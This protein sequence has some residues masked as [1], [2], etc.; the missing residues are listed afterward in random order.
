[1]FP[2]YKIIVFNAHSSS[3]YFALKGGYVCYGSGKNADGVDT[4]N[5]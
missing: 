5:I 1:M 2:H 3:T 4:E